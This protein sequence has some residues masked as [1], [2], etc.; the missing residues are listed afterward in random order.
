MWKLVIIYISVFFVNRISGAEIHSCPEFLEKSEERNTQVAISLNLIGKKLNTKLLQE[1]IEFKKENQD[2]FA[3]EPGNYENKYEIF[4]KT[5]NSVK[6]KAGL[7][8]NETV[9]DRSRCLSTDEIAEDYLYYNITQNYFNFTCNIDEKPY[10]SFIK[11]KTLMKLIAA[12]DQLENCFKQAWQKS[13][14]CHF[15]G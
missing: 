12:K 11:F 9:K 8:Y 5:C 4:K 15:C 7:I 1:F 14:V 10:K 6:D 2:N 13:T 3:N